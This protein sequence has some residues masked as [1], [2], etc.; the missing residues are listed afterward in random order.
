MMPSLFYKKYI[1]VAPL[2]LA[3]ERCLECEILSQQ[4]IKKPI[5]DLGCGD[6]VFSSVVFYDKY[7][8]IDTGI[9]ADPKEIERAKQKNIYNELLCCKADKIPKET[10]FYNTIFSNSVLEHIPLLDPVLLEA[11][12]LLGSSGNFYITVPNDNFD[13]F[14]MIATILRAAHCYSLAARFS[15]F[16]NHFWHHY[17][18]YAKKD[19]ISLFNKTGFEVIETKEYDSHALCFLNDCLIIFAIPSLLIKKIF[20]RW[21][22]FPSMRKC[23]AFFCTKF[24]KIDFNKH[25][26]INHG[27]LVFFHLRKRTSV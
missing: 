15:G 18:F 23:F 24:I 21:I 22:L 9:D 4:E 7:D 6:G 25:I 5:L 3:I 13:K 10:G 2:A 26:D 19:W 14:N 1:S 11:H 8:K 17:H 16:Y 12:R 20:G 27:G